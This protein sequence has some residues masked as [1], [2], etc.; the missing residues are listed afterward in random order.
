LAIG[1][2]Y[3]ALCKAN[4]RRNFTEQLGFEPA[5]IE[6]AES[7]LVD[8]APE[9]VG[10][11]VPRILKTNVSCSFFVRPCVAARFIESDGRVRSPALWPDDASIVLIRLRA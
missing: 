10:G 2:F 9:D 8:Q 7:D 1:E 5:H 6:G 3:F 4:D 11:F